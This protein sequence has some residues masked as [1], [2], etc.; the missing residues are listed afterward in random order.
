M[1]LPRRAQLQLD[2]Q[3][4]D[5]EINGYVFHPPANMNNTFYSNNSSAQTPGD[6]AKSAGGGLARKLDEDGPE[7]VLE[8]EKENQAFFMRKHVESF[9]I[10]NNS[11]F[12]LHASFAL[13]SALPP[14]EADA[15][16]NAPEKEYPDGYVSPFVF[17]PETLELRRG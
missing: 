3:I 12:P 15:D 4:V 1:S 16:G 14:P 7:R 2:R 8:R 10:T 5:R 13:H 17:E 6:D 11:L 9:R